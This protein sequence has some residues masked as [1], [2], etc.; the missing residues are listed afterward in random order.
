MK[1]AIPTNDGLNISR[2]ISASRGFLVLEIGLGQIL[3]EEIRWHTGQ[4]T[5]RSGEEI[6]D[7]IKD[8]S[9]VL[10]VVIEK[11]F[12]KQLT[13]KRKNIVLTSE[14]IITKAIMEYMEQSLRKESNT[15]CCP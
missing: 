11:P 14:T 5:S 12:C 15:C 7:Q 13:G 1:I 3:G 2:N 4:S 9:T 10:S 8:C 6:L